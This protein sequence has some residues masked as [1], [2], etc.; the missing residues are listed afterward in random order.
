MSNQ[1]LLSSFPAIDLHTLFLGYRSPAI[2]A[3]FR[4]E[5]SP[6]VKSLSLTA[7]AQIKSVLLFLTHTECKFYLL[8]FSVHLK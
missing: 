3:V 5:F 2:A 7:I 1:I 6:I 8:H 4:V